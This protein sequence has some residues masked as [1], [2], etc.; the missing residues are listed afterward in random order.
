MR[1]S[2][3]RVNHAGWLAVVLLL[4]PLAAFADLSPSDFAYTA[5]IET[6]G[7]AAIYRIWLPDSVYSGVRRTDLGDL[8]IFNADG[9]VVPHGIRHH[10]SS[11]SRE[12][13]NE[14]VFTLPIFPLYDETISTEHLRLSLK[15]AAGLESLELARTSEPTQELFAYLL[16]ARAVHKPL[17]RLDIQWQDPGDPGG[18]L[19]RVHVEASDDL[20]HWRTLVKHAT[21]AELAHLGRR[22]IRNSI[23]IHPT[24]AKYFRLRFADKSKHI[25]IAGVSA[26]YTFWTRQFKRMQWRTATVEKG[27]ADGEYLFRNPGPM[28][29]YQLD[30]GLPEK[31]T[32]AN[33]DLFSRRSRT[34]PWRLRRNT[35]L[36][37]LSHADGEV[38]HTR[39][40]LNEI[41]DPFWKLVVDHSG[42]GLGSG[43]PIV[44]FRWQ[45]HELLFVA[46][47][48]TPFLAAWGNPRIGPPPSDAADPFSR[49]SRT[50]VRSA[51]ISA[52]VA[53]AGEVPIWLRTADWKKWVLWTVLTAGAA[54]IVLLA[55]RL[56]RQMNR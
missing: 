54:V 49:L 6:Q 41:D 26:R 22:L 21:L 7:Q 3:A 32:L 27:K 16:D 19:V 48:Q 46:R 24:K 9:G 18:F 10:R 37:R 8:R 51:A 55:V 43:L 30:I 36:F 13:E 52:T 29:V 42:G 2:G 45:A 12:S 17:R 4:A 15:G 47:G 31:N 14:R 53:Q 23:H 50:D 20:E 35:Q 11:Q 56:Y 25:R 40:D 28:R 33:A 44:K 38:S 1:K 5:E 34:Q 39:I